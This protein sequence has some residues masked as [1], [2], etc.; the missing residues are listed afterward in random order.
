M[1]NQPD[2]RGQS[3]LT[4]TLELP[5]FPADFTGADRTILRTL[6]PVLQWLA[7]EH[8]DRL[9]A[10]G[11]RLQ[12]NEGWRSTAQ[13]AQIDQDTASAQSLA[14]L[15][16]KGL[17][18]ISAASGHSKHELV[19]ADGNPAAAAYDGEPI[20]KNDA[21]WAIYGAEAEALGLTWGGRWKHTLPS[22]EVTTDRPHVELPG[23]R[24]ELV[25]LFAGGFVI[26][27]GWWLVKKLL[28]ARKAVA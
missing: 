5:P 3:T 25:A 23:S 7:I 28:A 11:I 2:R 12:L 17:T 26:V 13:Q 19:D 6:S 4:V 22:G 10:R 21:T 1:E 20:P 8:H 9:G 24:A 14:D 18:G 16:A 15:Q 27:A